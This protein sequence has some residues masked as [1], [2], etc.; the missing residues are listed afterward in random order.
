MIT[1]KNQENF[2]VIVM[3]YKNFFVYVQRQIDRLFRSF[4]IFVKT[5]VNDIVVHSNILQKHL[6]HFKQIFDMFKI[7]N[8]FIKSKKIFIDYFIVHL[9]NQKID[10]FELIIV[11]K[12]LKII[13]RFFFYYFAIVE[14][15]FE[16]HELITKLCILIR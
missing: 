15:V 6:I 5:Y 4:R 16:F 8:I 1:H 13:S 10:F 2:N 14:N 7:N 3:N 9:L 12:K 11:E